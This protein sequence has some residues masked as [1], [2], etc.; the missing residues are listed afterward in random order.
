M[1]SMPTNARLKARRLAGSSSTYRMSCGATG[2]ILPRQAGVAV[3][4]QA[5]ER[6]LGELPDDGHLVT[7]GD[8]LQVGVRVVAA[9]RADRVDDASHEVEVLE[10][11][12]LG[13]RLDRAAV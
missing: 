3:P 7:G 6:L 2:A 4:I 11:G 9:D 5:L 1:T 10:L 12:H 8:Q 13:Q